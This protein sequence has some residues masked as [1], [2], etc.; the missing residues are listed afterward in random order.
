MKKIVF[1]ISFTLAALCAQAQHRVTG[2]V[3][4]VNGNPMIGTIVQELHS[5]RG[6]VTDLN[7]RYE[8]TTAP[9]AT[10]CFAYIGYETQRVQV[11]SKAVIDV[12]LYASSEADSEKTLY[13]VDGKPMAKADVDQ[14]PAESIQNMNVMRGVESVVLITTQPEAAGRGSSSELTTIRIDKGDSGKITINN[15]LAGKMVY[16]RTSESP[17]VVKA[18]NLVKH[19]DGKIEVLEN[20]NDIQPEKIQSV[21]VYKNAEKTEQFKQYGD[22]SNGVIYI[23]LKK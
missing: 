16:V 6:V 10:L 18:L 20:I 14:L 11:A 8:L 22:T 12:T 9:D 1:M 3:V 2:K 19:P 21:A 5:S 13:V 23:E 4:D 17:A 7:G 15:E